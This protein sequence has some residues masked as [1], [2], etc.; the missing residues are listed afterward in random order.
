MPMGWMVPVK[1]EHLIGHLFVEA[2]TR[3]EAIEIVRTALVD[4]R[5]VVDE[6]RQRSVMTKFLHA[7]CDDRWE[8]WRVALQGQHGPRKPLR[9]KKDRVDYE[10]ALADDPRCER[11]PKS[12]PGNASPVSRDAHDQP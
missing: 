11:P 10:L 2:A 7:L 4:T 3:A 5:I 12:R 8:P 1:S 9:M 6:T